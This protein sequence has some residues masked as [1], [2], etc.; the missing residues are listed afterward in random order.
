MPPSDPKPS[1]DP[2][3]LC[4]CVRSRWEKVVDLLENEHVFLSTISTIRTPEEQEVYL[5]RGTSWTRNSK[6]LP[7]P[8]NGLSLAVDVCPVELLT[9]KYWSPSSP[10][11]A[12]VGAAALE[13]GLRWGVWKKDKK[14]TLRNIDLGH[15][16]LNECACG[17]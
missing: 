14:G 6:H 10:L 8:P 3:K 11:W 2:A 1:R 13:V 12:K 17:R 16:F 4:P 9:T 5:K 15:L 7:Q